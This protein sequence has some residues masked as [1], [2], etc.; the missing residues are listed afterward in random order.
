MEILNS[1]IDYALSLPELRLASAEGIF[2]GCLFYGC[3]KRKENPLSYNMITQTTD[4]WEE[5]LTISKILDIN[6]KRFNAE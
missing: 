4:K 3:M 1:I 2:F 6:L 5:G